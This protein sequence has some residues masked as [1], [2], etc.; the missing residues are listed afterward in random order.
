[1]LCNRHQDWL[2]VCSTVDRRDLV[3][4]FRK[5]IGHVRSED[6]VISWRVQSL[7]ERE[8]RRVCWRRLRK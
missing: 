8:L 4:P 2:V 6:A 1:M 7:E 5:T 3:C